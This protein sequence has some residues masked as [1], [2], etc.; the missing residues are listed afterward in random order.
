[1]LAMI[2]WIL[3]KSEVLA[4]P[5]SLVVLATALAMIIANLSL[6]IVGEFLDQVLETSVGHGTFATSCRAFEA[7]F[8]LESWEYA[9][10]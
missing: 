7:A 10:R 5:P 3:T 2:S 4:S 1:M 8:L 9:H 6:S